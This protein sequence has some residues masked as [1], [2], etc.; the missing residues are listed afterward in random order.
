MNLDPDKTFPLRVSKDGKVWVE[1]PKNGST[2][3]KRNFP[4][5]DT[6]NI[7]KIKNYSSGFCVL[8]D[9]VKR[10][11]SLL[12]HYFLEGG[13]RYNHGK[14]WLT[15]N[16]RRTRVN[17]ENI[18]DIVLQDINKLQSIREPH[19]FNTQ[20]SFIPKQFFELDCTFY[21]ISEISEKLNV[22]VLNTSPKEK[23]TLSEEAL[24]SVKEIY[25]DDFIL[26]EKY[27]INK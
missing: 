9:P 25:K 21:D 26:Y 16:Y 7:N 2:T 1:I 22:P 8:R 5:T 24:K 12:S 6:L 18:A 23:I 14:K 15:K 11:K 19:H 13:G 20:L 4:F 3:I 17:G 10:F 27:V